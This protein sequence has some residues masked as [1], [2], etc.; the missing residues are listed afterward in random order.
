MLETLQHTGRVVPPDALARG[1][2]LLTHRGPRPV[3][4]WVRQLTHG[5]GATGTCRED[6]TS[7]QTREA[8]LPYPESQAE[9]WPLGSGM[10][11][12]ATTRVMQARLKGAG[13]H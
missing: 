10:G 9:G 7:V 6:L 3:M 8:F 4:R 5:R 11:E 12:R 1:L 13:M 2:H